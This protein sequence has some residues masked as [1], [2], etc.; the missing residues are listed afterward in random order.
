[1]KKVAF[2]FLTLDNLNQSQLWEKFFS[3]NDR[4]R[5]NIYT[6][7]K[8]PEKVS[9][10][11]LKDTFI[12][13]YIPTNHGDFSLLYAAIAMFT[14]AFL[15]DTE[16]DYF[17]LLSESAVPLVD[18]SHIWIVLEGSEQNSYFDYYVTQPETE[19]RGRLRFVKDA[20][21]YPTFFWHEFWC[22]LSRKH[23]ERLIFCNKIYDFLQIYTPEEHYFLNVLHHIEGVPLSEIRNAKTTFVN[24]NEREIRRVQDPSGKIIRQSVHPKTYTT[25][26]ADDLAAARAFD[27]W[28]MRKISPLCDVQLLVDQFRI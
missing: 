10:P 13:K 12:G 17:I 20:H 7:A 27:S 23:F 5:Y 1:M 21:N 9:S 2:C 24:W 25:L 16:N 3:L 8:F 22:V 26:M 6:H 4:D 15:A 11:L 14:H 18:F 19:H 28:F